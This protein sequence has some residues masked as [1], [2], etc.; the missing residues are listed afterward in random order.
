MG[1]LY[2]AHFHHT[3]I[4]PAVPKRLLAFV[5]RAMPHYAR[6]QTLPVVFGIDALRHLASRQILAVQRPFGREVEV[7]AD[8]QLLPNRRWLFLLSNQCWINNNH[9]LFWK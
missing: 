2:F 6:I 8:H 3:V 9:F 7:A 5:E 4:I 1:R